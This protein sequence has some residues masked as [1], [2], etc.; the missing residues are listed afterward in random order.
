MTDGLAQLLELVPILRTSRYELLLASH[1][2]NIM[3]EHH[4]GK[5]Y[6]VIAARLTQIGIAVPMATLRRYVL[7]SKSM[8]GNVRF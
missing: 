1:H 2:E 6:A 3:Q 5:T 8:K 7:R 4:D